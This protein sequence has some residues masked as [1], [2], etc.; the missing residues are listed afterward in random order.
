MKIIYPKK[1]IGIFWMVLHCLNFAI[2]SVMVRLCSQEG[3]PVFEI[4]FLSTLIAF[5]CMLAWAIYTKGKQ[6]SINTP[7]LYAVR[8]ILGMIGMILWFYVLKIIPLTEATAI[9]YT[10]PL[11]S[12]FAAILLLHERTDKYRIMAL[13]MGFIGVILVIRPGYAVIEMGALLAILVSAIW[14]I[15]DIVTKMQTRSET[16][17]TQTFYITLF[18]SLLSLPLAISI[19]QPPTTQQWVSLII[20][21]GVFLF[22]FFA[23]FQAY[24]YADLTLL[25]PIDFSRLLFTLLFAYMLFNEV[26]DIWSGVG[27]IIILSSAIYIAQRESLIK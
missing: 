18:I 11:F 19:W 25:L 13:I 8:V 1:I 26:M 12:A 24:R 7:W 4:F 14:A 20:L 9:S 2:M 6:L 22:N 27:A 10:S 16:L 17:S 21:G 5:F 3:L 15:V 23:I